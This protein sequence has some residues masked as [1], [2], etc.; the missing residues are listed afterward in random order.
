MKGVKRGGKMLQICGGN[1]HVCT[2][3]LRRAAL[4]TLVFGVLSP[5]SAGQ[6]ILPLAS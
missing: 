5:D 3:A 1:R 2:A 6:T 4:A